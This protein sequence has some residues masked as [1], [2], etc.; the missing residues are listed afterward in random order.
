MFMWYS[1]GSKSNICFA[2]S[3][4]FFAKSLLAAAYVGSVRL[5]EYC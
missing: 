5:R 4:N 1:L 2:N 3:L